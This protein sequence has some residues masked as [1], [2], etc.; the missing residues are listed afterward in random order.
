WRVERVLM[1]LTSVL[2]VSVLDCF[3]VGSEVR[4]LLFSLPGAARSD[5]GILPALSNV[6][7]SSTYFAFSFIPLLLTWD[8]VVSLDLPQEPP[9][10]IESNRPPAYWPSIT[11]NDNLV[12]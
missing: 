8:F 7:S 6:S 12:V 10:I 3:G 5:P 11:S 4:M 9:A 2:G 1:W